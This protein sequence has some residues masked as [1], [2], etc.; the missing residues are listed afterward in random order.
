MLGQIGNGIFN[1]FGN[2]G[3]NNPT[4]RGLGNKY[5]LYKN[6]EKSDTE[7]TDE[8]KNSTDSTEETTDATEAATGS[9]NST[10]YSDDNS[11]DS[12]GYAMSMLD[13]FKKQVN[14]VLMQSMG[15]NDPE[16]LQGLSG[17][18]GLNELFG[19]A[20]NGNS[21]SAMSFSAQFEINYQSVMAVAGE[22]GMTMQSTSFSLSASFEFIGMSSGYGSDFNPFAT[23]D[24]EEGQPTDMMSKLKDMFSPEKTAQ[25]I[26]DFALSFFPN[27]KQYTEGGDTQDSRQSFADIMSAA[28]QKGFDQ[29]MGI[30]GKVPEETEKEID[31]THSRVFDGFDDFVQNGYDWANSNYGSIQAYSSTFEMSYSSTAIYYS[32]D[33]VDSI[34][35]NHN[36]NALGNSSSY[37]DEPAEEVA[38][39]QVNADNETSQSAADEQAEDVSETSAAS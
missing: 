27:S 6:A 1:R 17:L 31:E 29:A 34:F 5:G 2:T 23:D 25:R 38:A 18:G 35:G 16:S 28:V 3:L 20:L 19:S 11:D 10:S 39:T 13:E 8:S 12:S 15:L 30:L 14:D 21:F 37:E 4:F 9:Q 26:L 7:E 24:T 22:N 32:A 33:E 36:A